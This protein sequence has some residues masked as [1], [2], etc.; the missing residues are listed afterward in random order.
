MRRFFLL[1]LI[2]SNLPVHARVVTYGIM[3]MMDNT[4]KNRRIR[5][6]P[7]CRTCFEH[8]KKDPSH[9]LF[10]KVYETGLVFRTNIVRLFFIIYLT[11]L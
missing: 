9:K 8:I 4:N 10:V 1:L 6:L 5:V 11:Q 3:I 7:L 2:P